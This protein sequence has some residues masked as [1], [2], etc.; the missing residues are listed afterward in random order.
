LGSARCRA[1]ETRLAVA[2]RENQFPVSAAGAGVLAAGMA[3]TLIGE[4]GGR[5]RTRLNK[6]K[7]VF[8][9]LDAEPPW[10]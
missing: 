3:P 4:G 10:F 7:G 5:A 6:G 2:L 8:K 1:L 9:H